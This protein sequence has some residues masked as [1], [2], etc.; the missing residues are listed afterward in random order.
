[1]DKSEGPTAALNMQLETLREELATSKYK[2]MEEQFTRDQNL[3][4]IARLKQDH[5]AEQIKTANFSKSL[6]NKKK[7]FDLEERRSRSVKQQKLESKLIVD[8]LMQNIEKEHHDTQQILSEIQKSIRNKE[9][10]V[11]RRIERQ[12]KNQEIAEAAANE[13][14]DQSEA[15]MRDKL[16]IQKM[17]SSFMRKKMDN[18]MSKSAQIDEAFKQIKTA[19]GV[20]N[21][22]EL[23]QRFLTREQTYSQ[24]L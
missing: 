21:V 4:V 11:R 15:E 2:K 12:K 16:Y 19:T 23:V 24:L 20:T 7:V 3:H 10:S 8:R 6:A 18:E 14:K 9:E 22:Q 13:S 5:L 1:M 17:W